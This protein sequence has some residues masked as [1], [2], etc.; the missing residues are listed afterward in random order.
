MSANSEE[1]ETFKK[2]HKSTKIIRIMLFFHMLLSDVM[3][4]PGVVACA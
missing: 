4:L 3:R 2:K 1:M